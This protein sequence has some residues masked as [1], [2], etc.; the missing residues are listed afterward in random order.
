MSDRFQT[1]SMEQLSAWMAQELLTTF[2]DEIGELRLQPGTGG[3]FTVHAGDTLVWDRKAEGG[4]P[5]I[6]ELKR[7]VRDV[8]APDK[9]LGHA[10]RK[11]PESGS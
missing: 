3:V 4:F 1:L 2:A 9:S 8:I 10:D 11:S 7:R 5:D 6:V